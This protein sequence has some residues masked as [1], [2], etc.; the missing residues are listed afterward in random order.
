MVLYVNPNKIAYFDSFRVEHI[1]EEIK[2][3]IGNKK[4]MTN[5]CNIQ[6]WD[7]IMGR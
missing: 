1:P 7:S 6:A 5:I 3:F 4:I 2:N